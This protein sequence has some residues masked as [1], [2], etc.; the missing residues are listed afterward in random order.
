[1]EFFSL[2][3]VKSTEIKRLEFWSQRFL[4]KVKTIT[5]NLSCCSRWFTSPTQMVSSCFWVK[6]TLPSLGPYPFLALWRASFAATASSWL[7]VVKATSVHD[8]QRMHHYITI[9]NHSHIHGA[10]VWQKRISFL[11]TTLFTFGTWL[12][13]W[14]KPYPS[15]IGFLDNPFFRHLAYIKYSLTKWVSWKRKHIHTSS[16]FPK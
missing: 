14:H 16:T 12:Y 2:F 11:P 5:G 10:C 4:D 9:T 1:M 8:L 3:V 13:L 6:C 15:Y 7:K